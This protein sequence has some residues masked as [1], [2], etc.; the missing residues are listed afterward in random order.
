MPFT[1]LRAYRSGSGV[2]YGNVG[3]AAAPG[4]GFYLAEWDPLSTLSTLTASLLRTSAAGAISW[5]K[6][7]DISELTLSTAPLLVLSN[8]T[9]VALFI[10][11]KNSSTDKR[12]SHVLLY[13]SDGTLVWQVQL[14]VGTLGKGF[15]PGRAAMDASNNIVMAVMDEDS[16]DSVLMK[17]SG[18]TGA[19]SWVVS[20]RH[21]SASTGS[22]WTGPVAF[23]SGGDIAAAPR[24]SAHTGSKRNYLQRL[25][26]A[27]GS[28]VWSRSVAWGSTDP[29][30][31]L[32][33]DPSDNIYV[34]GNAFSG[35]NGPQ[36]PVA[37]LD[38][39]GATLWTGDVK[40]P[41]PQ[42]TGP[43]ALTPSGRGMANSS[44]VFIPG[45][46]GPA[47]STSVRRRGFTYVPANGASGA[48]LFVM[49][50]SATSGIVGPTASAGESGTELSFGYVEWPSELET[51]LVTASG[52]SADDG[53]YGGYTKASVAFD[54]V[55]GTTA[56]AS[57]TYTRVSAGT[58]TPG[59]PPTLAVFAGDILIDPI[60]VTAVS[61]AATSLGAVTQFG[62]PS[63]LPRAN[64]FGPVSAFGTPSLRPAAV[65]LGPV[66]TF[67]TPVG[68]PS[69]VT[70]RAASLD[71][72]TQFGSGWV[73]K[74]WTPDSAR[75]AVWGEPQTRFGTPTAAVSI[76]VPA[77]GWQATQFGVPTSPRTVV[78]SGFQAS[79]FGSP[80]GQYVLRA[81]GFAVTHIGSPAG[82]VG[83]AAQGFT[84]TRFGTPTARAPSLHVATG[85]QAINFGTAAAHTAV[86]TR[87]AYFRT[88]FGD[89]A[90]ERTA[91]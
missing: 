90:C 83:V 57:A 66:T 71:T 21:S 26:G 10:E 29:F 85:F 80:T 84:C 54:L 56:L 31:G 25:S 42:G 6:A 76:S 8:A 49:S 74:D 70:C 50:G 20:T 4:G 55:T 89:H 22:D 47:P 73:Y 61:Y 69:P 67:G 68:M 23:L 28:V 59:S 44:G 16:S 14:P 43:Y 7:L 27:D 81:A 37:K 17:L 46:M 3:V 62:T 51:I 40:S 52:S 53:T 82:Q 48:T 78:A 86:R 87:S 41:A 5:Q 33:V 2:G 35:T 38:S 36:L 15:V 58:F 19:I 75:W 12:R 1:L 13:T 39:S 11:D 9:H 32:A 30:S 72:I 64:S 18:S 77:S 34:W 65:A 79:A 24:G 60:A 91:A 63:N 45:N 88:H